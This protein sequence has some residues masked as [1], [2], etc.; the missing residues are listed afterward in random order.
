[1]SKDKS[2][3]A[4]P[5]GQAAAAAATATEHPGHGERTHFPIVGI[6]ASAGG[7]EAFEEF[8]R[9]LPDDCGLAFVLVPHLDPGHASLLTEILQRS[10]AMPVVEAENGVAVAANRVY[11]IP[12]NREMAIVHGQLCVAV[13]ELPRGQRMPIDAFLR[14][15]ADD[16]GDQAIGVILSG[17]GSDGTL[18]MRAIHGAGGITL[19]QEPSSAK[20]PGMPGSVIHAAYATHVLPAA[21]MPTVLLATARQLSN[22]VHPSPQANEATAVDIDAVLT[23]LHASTGHDFSHYKKGT[24]GRRI[25]RRVLQHRLRSIDDYRAYVAA[26]P[27]EGRALFKDLLINVTRFFRDPEAFKVL[28]QE[29]LPQ[30]FADKP[31]DYVFR[32]WVAG[33]ASGEEAY[34]VAILVREFMSETQKAFKVQIYGT[35]LDEESIASARAGFYLPNIAADLTPAQ[36]HTFFLHEDAGYRVRKEIREMLVFAVQNVIKDP[37]F[38]QLDLICCRNVMIY[39]EPELQN[40][41]IR[42]LHYALRTNGVLFLSPAESIGMHAELFTAVNRKWKFYR[43]IGASRPNSTMLLGDLS[44]QTANPGRATHQVAGKLAPVNLAELT[45]RALLQLFAPASVV[46]D[47]AGNIVFVHGDTDRFLRPAPGQAT[48]SVVD[49]ALDSLRAELR[50]ALHR[51][52]EERTTTR[53]RQVVVKID[54]ELRN[55]RLSV[56][57]LADADGHQLLLVSFQEETPTAARDASTAPPDASSPEMRRIEEL[58]SEL[59]HTW[60]ALQSTIERQQVANEELMSSNEE[61]QSTNEELQSTIEELETSKEE[62]QSINEELVTVNGELQAN[63]AHLTKTQND[64]KNLLDNI[65]GGIIFLD[66]QLCIQRFT[67]E[68][69]D[70]YHLQAADVGR[71][72]ADIKSTIEARD[73]LI[74]AQAVLDSQLPG[75]QEVRTITGSY[76]QVRLKPYR[77]LDDDIDGVVM[78]FAD[79]TARIDANSRASAAQLFSESIVDTVR[80]PLLVLDGELQVIA[81]SR[82]FYQRFQVAKEE[83]IGRQL[84]DL[85]NRQWDLPAFRELLLNI[86]PRDEAVED[87]PVEV[88]IHGS[89]RVQMMLNARRL[90]GTQPLIL[91]AMGEVHS[92]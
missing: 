61:L 84:G 49:M 69:V 58:E 55:V 42:S 74:D 35:D 47:A 7:L 4:P 48:L 41:L 52:T 3:T 25:A 14:S 36:L 70:F 71:P 2:D 53:G 87:F 43:A 37:P 23:V 28:K 76:Y 78:T 75:E 80:E 32:I 17:T 85:A 90:A 13:P 46:T 38:S 68:A 45:R 31:A 57:P 65:S 62:L 27:E 22:N 9:H 51:A 30:L 34:S 63:T 86:L 26:H 88:D 67:S 33:C 20:F 73:L 6:G 91:L 50:S 92:P 77:T 19:V 24:I 11:I 59:A 66:Q 54:G 82:A 79:I 56:H 16:Q 64:L 1:M 10:T 29:I 8:F 21:D 5:P 18:G 72:L 89:G 81:A 39:L 83:T 12:P 15:L 60:E 40:Q 44:W